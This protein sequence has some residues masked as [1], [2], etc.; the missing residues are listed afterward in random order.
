MAKPRRNSRSKTASGVLVEARTK[1]VAGGTPSTL[2]ISKLRRTPKI[3]STF[4]GRR[5]VRRRRTKSLAD[6]AALSS[7]TVNMQ[8]TLGSSPSRDHRQ[9]VAT[10]RATR[11][12]RS[13]RCATFRR[14]SKGRF[15]ARAAERAAAAHVGRIREGHRRRRRQASA[16]W[17]RWSGKRPYC[18]TIASRSASGARAT[19]RPKPSASPQSRYRSTNSLVEDAPVTPKSTPAIIV[20]IVG[21]INPRWIASALSSSVPGEATGGFRR[22]RRRRAGPG[23]G[24][25]GGDGK[26]R[27]AFAS[28]ISS[29]F[30]HFALVQLC[31]K[32]G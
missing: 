13:V 1:R 30:C 7:A 16:A 9:P 21:A 12:D 10:R 19:A 28:S 15:P 3:R 25:G 18:G 27:R 20:A 32:R 6:Y 22:S 5:S 8:A 29:G 11:S 31:R 24:G 14:S 2:R 26:T 23:G 17:P 4:P